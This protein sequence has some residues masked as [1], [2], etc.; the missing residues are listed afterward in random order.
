MLQRAHQYSA[1]PRIAYYGLSQGPS[2]QELEHAAVS[3]YRTLSYQDQVQ[4]SYA[5]QATPTRVLTWMHF[6]P[7]DSAQATVVLF[8]PH[9]ITT[10]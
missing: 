1:D 10:L 3:S 7:F 2:A 5:H 6:V 9:A 8:P 4:S